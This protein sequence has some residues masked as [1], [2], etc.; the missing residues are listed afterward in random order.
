[1]LLKKFGGPAIMDDVQKMTFKS[2][3]AMLKGLVSGVSAQTG[4]MNNANFPVTGPMVVI[5]ALPMAGQAI[6]LQN[7]VLTKLISLVEKVIDAA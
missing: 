6:K 2:E 7:D 3:I 5:P 1:M 4:T